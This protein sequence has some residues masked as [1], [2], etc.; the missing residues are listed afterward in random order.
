MNHLCEGSIKLRNENSE[1]RESVKSA[2]DNRRTMSARNIN[3]RNTKKDKILSK[4]FVY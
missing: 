2:R 1:L 4:K 3:E